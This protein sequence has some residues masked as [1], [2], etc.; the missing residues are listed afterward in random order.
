VL[1]SH[2]LRALIV[3]PPKTASVTLAAVLTAPPFDF[4]E[5]DTHPGEPW[6]VAHHGQFPP[7]GTEDYRVYLTVRH[8]VARAVSMFR[9]ARKLGPGHPSVA[10]F[11]A[12][13]ACLTSGEGMLFPDWSLTCMKHLA[14][15][16]AL[17]PRLAGLV[18]TERLTEDLTAFGP[19]PPNPG[20][21]VLNRSEGD[22]PG[23]GP[24]ERARLVEWG[25]DDLRAVARFA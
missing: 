9:A 25:A 6:H 19:V 2:R 11:P 17:P 15:N 14:V 7:E 21:P 4:F 18:R 22:T 16:P 3:L 5:P 20:L 12:F 13:V 23:V 8:P 1:V 10:S 24:H